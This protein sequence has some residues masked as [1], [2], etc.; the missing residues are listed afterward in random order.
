MNSRFLI[1]RFGSLSGYNS[2]S[3]QNVAVE[4]HSDWECNTRKTDCGDTYANAP[5]PESI[6]RLKAKASSHSPERQRNFSS[7]TDL[8]TPSVEKALSES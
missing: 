6:V 2:S 7:K 1:L 3:K 8:K 4:S 5:Q